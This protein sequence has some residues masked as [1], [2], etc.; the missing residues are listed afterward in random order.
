MTTHKNSQRE[1]GH[2]AGS[3]FYIAGQSSR[4]S[5]Q[6]LRSN[7]G[8]IYSIQYFFLQ[9]LVSFIRISSLKI[10]KTGKPRKPCYFRRRPAY[11]NTDNYR[12]A[13]S[14]DIL[15]NQ[16]QNQVYYLILSG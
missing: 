7:S 8:L 6:T 4:S 9:T 1:R 14:G 16:I 15:F 10:S 13:A 3:I 5:A 11:S 12:R 2:M